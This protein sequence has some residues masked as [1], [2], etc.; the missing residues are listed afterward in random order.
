MPRKFYQ[1]IP[2]IAGGI[3][4]QPPIELVILDLGNSYAL[5]IRMQWCKIAA[6]GDPDKK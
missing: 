2:L 1:R 3:T 4:P 5:G 6:N